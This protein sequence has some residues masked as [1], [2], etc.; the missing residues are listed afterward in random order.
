M[1]VMYYLIYDA[2]EHFLCKINNEPINSSLS[3]GVIINM[4]DKALA[5]HRNGSISSHKYS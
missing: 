1:W 2:P 5:I 3:T 4:S